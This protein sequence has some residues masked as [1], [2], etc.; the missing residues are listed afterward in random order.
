V[1]VTTAHLCT[2]FLLGYVLLV[3]TNADYTLG[4]L[5]SRKEQ[6]YPFFFLLF[7]G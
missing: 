5:H 3:L 2:L 4:V 1:L 6:H 7:K